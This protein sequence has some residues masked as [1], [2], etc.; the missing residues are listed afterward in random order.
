MFPQEVTKQKVE[1]EG[2]PWCDDC[3]RLD[4]IERG[5]AEVFGKL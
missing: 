4:A 5:D 1:R 2:K 3:P